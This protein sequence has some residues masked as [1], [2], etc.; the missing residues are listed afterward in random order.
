MNGAGIEG[1]APLGDSVAIAVTETDQ[2]VTLP[3][4]PAS[5]PVIRLA[6]LQGNIVALWVKLGNAAVTGSLTT[7]MRMRAGSIEEP[8]YVAIGAAETHLSIFCE[9]PPGTVMLTVGKFVDGSNNANPQFTTI[10]LGNATDTTLSRLS[11]GV[12]GVEGVP[13]QLA[14]KQSIWIPAGAMILRGGAAAFSSLVIGDFANGIISFDPTVFEDAFF[15]VKMPKSWNVGTFTFRAVWSHA[16]T[17]TNF[18][19]AWQLAGLPLSDTDLLT[20]TL[21][22]ALSVNDTGGTTN[23]LYISPESGALTLTTPLRAAEDVVKFRFG[24]LTA[25]AGDTMTIDARLHGVM[26]FYTTNAPNDA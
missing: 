15:D 9:G 19:V 20:T 22:D 26:L 12:L 18:G 24:R 11:A 2:R 14:G 8:A 5:N 10:E 16:A 17:V 23:A 4:Y 25:D 6:T 13:V 3:A 1:F 21:T 7:S